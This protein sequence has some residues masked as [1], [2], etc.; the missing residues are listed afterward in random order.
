MNSN[1]RIIKGLA[2]LAL[3][4]FNAQLTTADAAVTF[5]NTPTAVSNTYT[6]FITLQIGGLTNGETV[7]VQEFLDVN[8]N[9]V[10]DARDWLVQQF[11]LTDG[12][13]ST[14]G[15]IV[16]SN[17][18]G[19]TTPTN[20]AITAQLS[21]NSGNA[22][23]TV[24]GKYLF[25]LSSPTGRFT[26]ITNSFSVTNLAYAQGFTGSV[27]CGSTNVPNAVVML[28]PGQVFNS[29][30][31][32]AV[33]AN[34]SGNYTIKAPP[35]TYGLAALQNNYLPSTTTAPMLTL[36]GT[37]ITTN[38]S[39]TA[40][41]N[42]T[43]GQI[44]DAANASLGLPGVL[45]SA[46]GPNGLMG[47]AFTDTNGNFTVGTI[48]GTWSFKG[49]NESSLGSHGYVR[50]Q[51]STNVSAGQTGVTLAVPKATA[52]FYGTLKDGLGNP[53]A[54][55]EVDAYDNNNQYEGDGYTDANGNYAVG[56]LG[57][58]SDDPWN[59]SISTDNGTTP[60]NYV[61]SQPAFDVNGWGTNLTVGQ[62]VRADFVGLLATNLI[63]GWLKDGS[64]N[65]ISNVWVGANAT[66]NNVSYQNGT[67]TDGTGRYAINVANGVWQVG[68]SCGG[69]SDS[70]G[71]QYL[72]PDGQTVTIANN[73][74]NVSFTALLPASWINGS[75]KDNSGH[76]IANVGVNANPCSGGNG[77]YVLTDTNGSYSLAVANG[78]WNVSVS[79]FGNNS[80]NAL[81]Y[82]CQW[83]Q[84]VTVSNTTTTVN[85]IAPPAPYHITGYLTNALTGQGI[86]N[87]GLPAWATINGV[88][89][90][91]YARTDNNGFYSNNVANGTWSVDVNCGCSE[92]DCLSS[93][94]YLCPNNQTVTI[95]NDDVVA[96]FAAVPAPY[97]ITGWVKNNAGQPFTNLDVH[98][99]ATIG[100]NSY[101]FDSYTDANGNY[102]FQVAVGQWD[103]GVD[104]SGLGSGCLCP[105]DAIVNIVGASVVTNF[106]VQSCGA[107]QIL[108]TSPLPAGQV[109]SYY[110]T[111]LQ[112]SSCYPDFQWALIS[113][114]LPP[115]LTGNPF[116]GE[117]YGTPITNGTFNFTVQVTDGNSAMTNRALS[118]TISAPAA[119]V[120]TYYVEKIEAFRQLDAVNQILDTNYG[121][122]IGRAGIIQSSPDSVPIANLDLPTG[123]VRGFPPGG[124][125]IELFYSDL[126]PSQA[127]FDAVYTNGNYTFAI[128]TVHDGFQFPV[129]AMPVAVYPVAPRL[130]NF[131]AA[132]AITPT[133]AFTLQ[134][135]DPPDATTNDTIWVW[136]TDASGNTVFSTPYP[137]TNY[138][139]CLPGTATSAVVPANTLRLGSAYTGFIA[140]FRVNGVNTTSYAGALG[141]TL[142][143]VVTDFPLVT[144]SSTPPPVLSQPT[145]I[146][147]TQFGFL[148]SGTSGQ[149]YTVLASTNSALHLSNWFPVLTTNLSCSSV[150]IPDCQATNKQRYYRVKVGP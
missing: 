67:D 8:T 101:W 102:S 80:L 16:N 123:G 30:A 150:F 55:I 82:L 128:A 11:R 3:L 131:A 62:A 107:L 89:Y 81:G 117:I 141:M 94:N 10:I 31:Q 95:S 73:N 40:A 52:L 41:T 51:S 143:A 46:K 97:Q 140:F 115:G 49:G 124:S 147:G 135:S 22:L 6:G 15:G 145:R 38:L 149:N 25:K 113:G 68:V 86:A 110:D 27:V 78:C 83:Q 32:A 77:S 87:V 42:S 106:T 136:I 90:L 93:S 114:S 5:T 43:S 54:G 61:F 45:L 28:F 75:V 88:Q 122:F 130:G 2:L 70:L 79:S 112:A 37:T 108:T 109:G 142:V 26:P 65:P 57:G 69:G 23:Q 111:Y 34:N 76:P 116:T 44:V 7:V 17:V 63:S 120:L 100:A 53:M 133:N 103:V 48:A 134:W 19:D 119:D 18:P 66:I 35:G 74:T 125:G 36:G 72:C 59:A 126:Y 33:V 137:P 39:L 132:Q 92:G 24:A 129:L 64:G 47:I 12:L 99:S 96:S 58:L 56:V 148:L 139:A 50:L 60:T 84:T 4:A 14:I 98:A 138:P 146:S 1:H 121:P 118:L 21:F 20:G 91:Q 85:F 104:C 29:S 9:G 127:A 105:D 13:A 144:P 71:S